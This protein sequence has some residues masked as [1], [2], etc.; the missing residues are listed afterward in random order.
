[1]PFHVFVL[2]ALL[3]DPPA[4][5][6]VALLDAMQVELQRNLAS[7]VL[8]EN[9]GPYFLGYQVREDRE[10]ALVARYGALYVDDQTRDRRLSV[11]VRVGDYAFDSSSSDD[12][13]LYALRGP[14]YAM[15]REAPLD[16]S[17]AA[18][19]TS[20]WLLTDEKYKAAL[21]TYLKKKGAQV[22]DVDAP[23]RPP[24]FSRE[25][26]L[27]HLG[28]SR[29][30][31]F[32]RDRWSA[33]A[34]EL[35]ARLAREKAFFDSEV[36]ITANHVTRWFVTSEGTRVIT[37]QPAIAIHVQAW[38]RADDGQLLDDSRDWY[39]RTEGGLPAEAQLRAETE[40]LVRELAALRTA[41]IIDPY[42]GPALL[43]PAAAGVLIHE[44][45]GHRLEG[46]RLDADAE[47][48]TFRGQLGKA[49]LP[50]F[51]SLSDD[52]SAPTRDGVDLNGFYEVDQEGVRARAVTLVQDGIL[53]TFLTSR[54]P[55]DGVALSNGHG[56]AQG[57]RRPVARMANLILEAKKT[58]TAIE[59]KRLLIAEAKRQGRPFA[60]IVKDLIAG[61]TNTSSVG[62]QAFKGRPRRVY[63]V[64]VG[65][66][67]ETLVRGAELVGTPL[68]A[69]NRILAA[70]G[71]EGVSNGFCGAESGSIPVSTTSPSLLL[72]ELELQRVLDGRD[73]P[74]LLPAP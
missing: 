15:R 28:A 34:R 74:P 38:A 31:Q 6:R 58:F 5:P 7:L 12:S 13:E 54:H 23:K 21:F 29:P 47:N 26:P 2:F 65:T 45:I 48:K 72:Q 59:L 61:H 55:V 33:L 60:L 30:L 41:P 70:G 18:L 25:A 17:W 39:A 11:D 20:L 62:F 40:T 3:Q 57:V 16:D 73:R 67:E 44:V 22:Y 42:T 52:P 9:K 37:E 10:T 63:K 24:S 4:D 14:G 46:D 71:S 51:L 36:R 27:V 53:K 43:E 50:A 49:V 35:S 1:M 56:R 66:G 69:L 68:S 64:D 19:R 32:S 8:G